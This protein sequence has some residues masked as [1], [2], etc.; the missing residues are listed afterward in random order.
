M[1]GYTSTLSL[2]AK[3]APVCYE[4]A[5]FLHSRLRTTKAGTHV[6]TWV[7]QWLQDRK[8]THGG[9]LVDLIMAVYFLPQ[10]VVLGL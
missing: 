9:A 2:M 1:A 3:E 4:R 6:F 7:L 10:I 5:R 8:A